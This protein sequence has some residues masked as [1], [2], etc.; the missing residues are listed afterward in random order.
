M[1]Y[2][3]LLLNELTLFVIHGFYPLTDSFLLNHRFFLQFCYLSVL[4]V[5][6]FF[7]FLQL[8]QAVFQSSKLSQLVVL[9]EHPVIERI[10]LL[11]PYVNFILQVLLAGMRGRRS[12]CCYILLCFEFII[13][14]LELFL[15]LINVHLELSLQFFLL[16]KGF[17]SFLEIYANFREYIVVYL[18]VFLEGDRN[19]TAIKNY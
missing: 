6:V 1:L 17:L 12:F 2:A 10:D 16:F 7:Q 14:Q 11:I 19:L 18:F 3:G 9:N 5:Q 13:Q 8:N 4:D 15:P